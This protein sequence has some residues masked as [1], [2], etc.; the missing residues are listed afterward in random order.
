M[1]DGPVLCMVFCQ[2][3]EEDLPSSTACSHHTEIHKGNYHSKKVQEENRSR[4]S[5]FVVLWVDWIQ[6]ETLRWERRWRLR[7]D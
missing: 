7:R 1:E 6:W 5:K 3:G 4:T 2:T